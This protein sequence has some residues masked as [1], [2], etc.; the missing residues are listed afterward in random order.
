MQKF[1]VD[2]TSKLTLCMQP[3]RVLFR[4]DWE[5]MSVRTLPK[6]FGRLDVIMI[7]LGEGVDM[8]YC[9]SERLL[10]Y[11][12]RLDI[13]S[14]KPLTLIQKAKLYIFKKLLIKYIKELE[15]C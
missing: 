14:Y 9:V 8:P 2:L 11:G 4:L 10:Q 1:N 3:M 15:Q 13:Y 7:R 6:E 12:A 5:P